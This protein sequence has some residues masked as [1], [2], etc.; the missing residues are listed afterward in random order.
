MAAHVAFAKR[1]QATQWLSL[2]VV[3]VEVSGALCKDQL[4]ISDRKSQTRYNLGKELKSIEHNDTVSAL[5]TSWI[6]IVYH[7]IV[8]SCLLHTRLNERLLQL[9]R[10]VSPVLQ[11]RPQPDPYKILCAW[12]MLSM[13]RGDHFAFNPG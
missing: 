10:R 6:V 3:G 12:K 7:A 1:L 2:D 11:H 8:T 9:Q 13:L 4:L 5:F